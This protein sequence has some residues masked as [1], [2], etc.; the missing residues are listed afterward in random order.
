[1]IK[2]TFKLIN[3]SAVKY[4]R[5]A[6]LPRAKIS[7]VDTTKILMIVSGN[8]SPKRVKIHPKVP[9]VMAAIFRKA[10]TRA[11]CFAPKLEATRGWDAWDTPLKKDVAMSRLL[12]IILYTTRPVS[13]R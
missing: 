10:K 12:E 11:C 1:M 2:R 9:T 6:T 5:I 8:R 13:P 7:G 3:M 4:S